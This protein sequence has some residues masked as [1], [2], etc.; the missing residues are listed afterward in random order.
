MGIYW[1][2]GYEYIPSFA[3][4]WVGLGNGHWV[5]LVSDGAASRA[6]VHFSQSKI[7]IAHHHLWRSLVFAMAILSIGHGVM[8]LEVLDA[9]QTLAFILH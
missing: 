4:Y 1:V 7:K 6:A 9:S 5:C 2:G 3:S 8:A